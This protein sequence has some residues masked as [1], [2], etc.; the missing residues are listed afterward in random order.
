MEKVINIRNLAR[1]NI[2][3]KNTKSARA[4]YRHCYQF[5][6]QRCR[7]FKNKWWQTKAAGLLIVADSNN[8]MEHLTDTRVL[9]AH[10][11]LA[12]RNK[13]VTA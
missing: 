13:V 1:N 2:L 8:K 11:C 3:S 7:G 5:L 9:G 12:G 4:R 6:L 10:I